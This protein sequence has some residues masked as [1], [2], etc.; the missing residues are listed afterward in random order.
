MPAVLLFV[1][2]FSRHR[3]PGD[4]VRDLVVGIA[5]TLG[6]VAAITLL[7]ANGAE[8][9]YA[10]SDMVMSTTIISY[11]GTVASL[12]MTAAVLGLGWLG[13]TGGDRS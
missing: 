3:R 11:R 4:G 8:R 7:F 13:G 1:A 10:T 5:L 6:A 12:A 9:T 2:Y